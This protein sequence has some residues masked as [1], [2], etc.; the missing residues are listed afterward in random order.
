MENKLKVA[1]VLLIL[2]VSGCSHYSNIPRQRS[3]FNTNNIEE[4]LIGKK[5]EKSIQ[6]EFDIMEISFGFKYSESTINRT[7]I[8]E[9]YSIKINQKIRKVENISNLKTNLY[10]INKQ[11]FNNKKITNNSQTS[12]KFAKKKDNLPGILIFLGILFLWYFIVGIYRTVKAFIQIRKEGNKEDI[13]NYKIKIFAKLS[14]T[15]TLL[16]IGIF[17]LALFNGFSLFIYPILLILLELILVSFAFIFGY[18]AIKDDRTYK[19]ILL[20]VSSFILSILALI[21]SFWSL[22]M[23][24]IVY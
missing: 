4:K 13:K 23:S 19:I 6:N 22:I 18:K 2:I 21:V 8:I 14:I 15:L 17:F 10:S 20:T 1:V 7:P 3:F 11:Y 12:K 9:K 5:T 24:T 16:A